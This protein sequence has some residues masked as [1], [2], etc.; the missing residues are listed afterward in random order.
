MEGVVQKVLLG[1]QGS[2]VPPPF[3]VEG[4][5]ASVDRQ[6]DIGRMAETGRGAG[7]GDEEGSLRCAVL[8]WR[9]RRVSGIFISLFAGEAQQPEHGGRQQNPGAGDKEKPKPHTKTKQRR[10]SDQ[11]LSPRR[12][13]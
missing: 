6:F 2:S 8:R 9:E 7:H 3:S 12:R 11:K 1:S 10:E 5:T 4:G 13:R